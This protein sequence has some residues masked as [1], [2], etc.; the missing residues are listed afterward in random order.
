MKRG[1]VILLILVIG[2]ALY[3]FK[4]RDSGKPAVDEPK[5]QAVTLKKHSEAFN[6]S[7]DNAMT[8]YFDMKAAFVDGDST[9]VKD[10]TAKF[11]ALLDS[12]P[13]A[14]LKT[15]TTGIFETAA[16]NLADAK[17]NAVSLTRQPN[18]TEMRMD[19][20]GISDVLFPSF[21]KTINYEGRQLYLQN[22]PMAFGEDKDANWISYSSEI[23][24]PYMGKNHPEFKNS[25]LGCG[26]VKDSIFAKK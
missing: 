21:F 19:F 1:L 10:H 17:M 26:T 6:T 18:I 2:F 12:I 23:V 11:I 14:E 3:W 16:S 20:R 8:A 15:D 5:Q 25:M 13:L 9:K 4:F 24:N 7:V 22:C